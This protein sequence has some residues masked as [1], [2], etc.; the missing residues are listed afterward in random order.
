[1]GRLDTLINDSHG[2]RRSWVR[3]F[4]RTD[5]AVASA[6]LFA[7]RNVGLVGDNLCPASMNVAA[8]DLLGAQGRHQDVF[9]ALESR[10]AALGMVAAVLGAFEWGLSRPQHGQR[11]LPHG[12][13]YLDYLRDHGYRL[14]S[15]EMFLAG[16]LDV[17][18]L[19]AA[20]DTGGR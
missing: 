6:Q 10:E 7:A 17:A 1:M 5:G 20:V 13:P 14:S 15:V 11:P 2:P 3:Q 19:R 16:H 18:G 12:R 9:A 4:L 8:R